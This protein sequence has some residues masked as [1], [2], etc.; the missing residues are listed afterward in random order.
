M[1]LQLEEPGQ[2]RFSGPRCSRRAQMLLLLGCLNME[3]CKDHCRPSPSLSWR[4]VFLLFN[5]A[6]A[7]KM[8]QFWGININALITA[9]RA[10]QTEDNSRRLTSGERER[11]SSLHLI[12]HSSWVASMLR[13]VTSAWRAHTFISVAAI[14]SFYAPEQPLNARETPESDWA[15]CVPGTSASS[16]GR[17][18]GPLPLHSRFKLRLRQ[19]WFL[20]CFCWPVHVFGHN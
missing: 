8:K 4:P 11:K 20:V 12:L 3:R 14:H 9:L 6:Y 2:L 7:N 15:K 10:A 1:S 5:L 16:P 19:S 17:S 18:L 13:L